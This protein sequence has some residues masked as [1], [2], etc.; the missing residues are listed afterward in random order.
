MLREFALF[1]AVA[2]FAGG[3]L[4][5]APVTARAD[6]DSDTGLQ[7]IVVTAQKRSESLQT[8]P[9]AV[10]AIG[11]DALTQKGV[12]SLFDLPAL[13]PNLNITS[14]EGNMDPEITLRGIG[15]ASFNDNTE[16]AVASYLDEFVLNPPSAKLG[17]LFDLERVE[18]LRGPQGTLYGKNST[19]GAINF[20]TRRPD[21]T[22]ETDVTV[23]SARYG[24]YNLVVGAQTGLTDNLSA[25]VSIQ[26]NYSD[27]Y[28]FN[29]LTDQRLNNT[30]DWAGRLGL[31]YK[32][33]TV[34][35]YLKIF[36]YHSDTNGLAYTPIGVNADGSPRADNS[37]PISGYIPPKNVDVMAA[38]PT[39]SNV[40][41]HGATLNSDFKLGSLTL[42][43]VTGYLGTNGEF[44]FDADGSPFNLVYDEH[45]SYTQ[46]LTQ[47]LRL[48]SP[49]DA[50]LLW[51]AGA[52][53]FY[54]KQHI[55]FPVQI[56]FVPTLP[57]F[58]LFDYESTK[59]Y[60]A[61][62]DG[63]FKVNDSIDLFA[64]VRVTNDH[65]S[66]LQKNAFN[67]ATLGPLDS[68]SAHTWTKPTERVGLN[69][70]LGAAT[71]VYASYNRGYRSGEYDAGFL[72]SPA[73]VGKP[74]N[75]EYV[76]N[77]EMGLKTTGLNN[78]LRVNGDVFYMQFVDQQ[79]PITPP[80]G[81]CCS[82]VNAGKARVYGFEVEGTA[83]VSP[84]LEVQLSGTVVNSR[85]LQF[86]PSPG[87]SYA[88]QTLGRAPNYQI[89][90][91]PEY[92]TGLGE[93]E[94][95][96]APEVNVTGRS[97]VQAGV[98]SYGRDIQ[99]AYTIVNAQF[100]YRGPAQKYSAFIYVK[101]LTD[102]RYMTY[103]SNVG[104][105]AVDQIFYSP[106]LS[107]GITLMVK[108]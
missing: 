46:E 38:Q 87:V 40:R 70:H 44:A 62:A 71:L 59:S 55:Q 35:A 39:F 7:E 28:S 65:K 43:S 50:R 103:F 32:T 63:T 6:E 24:T 41:T 8:V 108:F 57:L 15:S 79:V 51:I 77:Y 91:A 80:G 14:P 107:Y 48:A 106:P 93:G 29:T 81:I 2:I 1:G 22:T 25:R 54:Q 98:D 74:V 13:V 5:V 36:A 96:L 53:F 60:A 101:N 9:I 3:T 102:K 11:S 97:R 69:L 18:V 64:G 88:G 19:G 31:R 37:S 83:V 4:L 42:T 95:F 56:Y 94:L 67:L 104:I 99:R 90:L 66:F 73:Q 10:T 21:G 61:F 34:D 33:D 100:G 89:R 68:L 23:T 47:E 85:Y 78:R 72:T 20:I 58:D 52:S 82:L 45:L 49:A 84:N 27:G 86:A 92:H 75:P 17:Q 76:N 16:T 30:D 12:T 26:R 105:T